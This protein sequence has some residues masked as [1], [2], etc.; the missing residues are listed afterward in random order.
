MDSIK[1][2]VNGEEKEISADTS[3]EKLVKEMNMAG[4]FVVE[5]NLDIL[6]KENYSVILHE[7][8][9]VEVVGFFGGG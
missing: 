2:K 5:L 8:D 7:G 9:N 6:P 3:V 1:I 4:M